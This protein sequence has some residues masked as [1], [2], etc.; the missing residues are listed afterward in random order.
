MWAVSKLV[1]DDTSVLPR[2]LVEQRVLDDIAV[3][4]LTKAGTAHVSGFAALYASLYP[5][6]RRPVRPTRVTGRKTPIQVGFTL[7][8]RSE[9]LV[10]PQPALE[11]LQ[12][13]STKPNIVELGPR[14]VLTI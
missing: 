7:P 11:E 14:L 4:R 2:H 8:A 10:I 3:C 5:V 6:P 1:T 12:P 9:R 13:S